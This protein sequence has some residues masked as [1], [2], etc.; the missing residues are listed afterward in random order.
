MKQLRE[1]RTCLFYPV[2]EEANKYVHHRLTKALL[3][4]VCQQRAPKSF[5]ILRELGGYQSALLTKGKYDRFGVL[6]VMGN[7][8]S[9]IKRDSRSQSFGVGH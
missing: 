1:R 5:T 3:Q 8:G 4:Y 2:E 6:H 7:H 9:I